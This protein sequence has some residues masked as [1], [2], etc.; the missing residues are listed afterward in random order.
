METNGE[1][2]SNSSIDNPPKYTDEDPQMEIPGT[3]QPE[4]T[5]LE[6]IGSDPYER[7]FKIDLKLTIAPGEEKAISIPILTGC[8]PSSRVEEILTL[9]MTARRFKKIL[10]AVLDN[11]PPKEETF[12]SNPLTAEA[13]AGIVDQHAATNVL[14][15]VGKAMNG[16]AEHDPDFDEVKTADGKTLEEANKEML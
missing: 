7:K 6:D 5:K 4:S 16:E 12:S 13:E 2:V 14:A 3:E 10:E 8:Y 11:P 1:Y 9:A 15:E